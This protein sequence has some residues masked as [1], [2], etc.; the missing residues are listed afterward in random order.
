[1]LTL[2]VNSHVNVF[3]VFIG[4][5]SKWGNPYSHLTDSLARYIV[6]TREEA[7][8]MYRDWVQT[9]PHLMAAL[10]ELKGKRL[11]CPGCNPDRQMCHGH[12]LAE[13]ADALP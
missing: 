11:G 13:L 10:V 6:R 3:D 4:R 8:E 1:M 7:V 9:Q 12:I 5:P 2:V